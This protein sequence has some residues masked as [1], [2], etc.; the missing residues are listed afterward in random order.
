MNVTI[1]GEPCDIPAGLTVQELLNHLSLNDERIAIERNQEI[2]RR[3]DWM[4]TQI[5]EGDAL[6]IVHF[7]GGGA[8]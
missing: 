1:N 4:T 3:A 5:E 2:A 8:R 7:V 6:E